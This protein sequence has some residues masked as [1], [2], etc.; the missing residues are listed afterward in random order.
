MDPKGHCR[1]HAVRYVLCK[2]GW[3]TVNGQ[4][5]PNSVP[6][7][8]ECLSAKSGGLWHDLPGRVGREFDSLYAGVG[9]NPAEV[10]LRVPLLRRERY[11]KDQ[12]GWSGDILVLKIKSF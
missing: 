9:S 5:V 4:T 12:L 3:S 6:R 10:F 7:S 8:P 11:L 2:R 1:Q